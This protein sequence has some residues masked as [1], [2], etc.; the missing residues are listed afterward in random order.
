MNNP[1]A[2]Q[3]LLKGMYWSC[4]HISSI[5]VQSR[6]PVLSFL[7]D[8]NDD[9]LIIQLMSDLTGMLAVIT[10]F[11]VL[12]KALRL[13]WIDEVIHCLFDEWIDCY[14]FLPFYSLALT[15]K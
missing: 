12:N 7:V 11:V 6:G 14:F 10:L 13:S 1:T 15:L 9:R 4:L 3:L 8:K 5:P 2:I